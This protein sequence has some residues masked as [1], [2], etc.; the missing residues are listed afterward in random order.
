MGFIAK[1]L[2]DAKSRILAEKEQ[3]INEIKNNVIA[4][5]QSKIDEINAL[6][7]DTLN[8]LTNE[9]SQNKQKYAEEY[10]AKIQELEN[11]Y[12][13]D[14]QS[15][16]CYSEKKKEELIF[17]YTLNETSKLEKECSEVIAEIDKQISK[18]GE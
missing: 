18:L 8:K 6:R 7:T 2:E 3:K 13:T 11:Q 17:N 10:R 4:N 14:K 12:E 5:N 15:I 16:V 9:F 1:H